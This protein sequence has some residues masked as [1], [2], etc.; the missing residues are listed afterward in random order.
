M[1][2]KSGKEKK[3]FSK[4]LAKIVR[5]FGFEIIDQSTLEIASNKKFANENQLKEPSII[6]GEDLAKNNL[7]LI[8]SVGIKNYLGKGASNPPALI[9]LCY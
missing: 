6:F 9:S 3:F 2:N 5:K 7:N 1:K 8:Y 4:F